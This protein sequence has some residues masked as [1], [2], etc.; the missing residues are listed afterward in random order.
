LVVDHDDDVTFEGQVA[1]NG[2]LGF[3]NKYCTLKGRYFRVCSKKGGAGKGMSVVSFEEAMDELEIKRT[4]GEYRIT[5]AT[6]GKDVVCRLVNMLEYKLWVTALK[7]ALN[8]KGSEMGELRK[9]RKKVDRTIREAKKLHQRATDRE[10]ERQALIEEKVSQEKFNLLKEEEKE[11]ALEDWEE[12]AKLRKKESQERQRGATRKSNRTS[13]AKER[14]KGARSGS[15]PR[16][17]KSGNELDTAIESTVNSTID[18]SVLDA[19]EALDTSVLSEG[20]D[21]TSRTTDSQ[22]QQE[23]HRLEQAQAEA[24]IVTK[25]SMELFYEDNCANQ[26]AYQEALDGIDNLLAVASTAE[27][28]ELCQELFGKQPVV[29]TGEKIRTSLR[30]VAQLVVTTRRQ[31][32]QEVEPES[33]NRKKRQQGKDKRDKK[34]KKDK[35]NRRDK[36]RKGEET[37]GAVLLPDMLADSGTAGASSQAAAAPAAPAA[38]AATATTAAAPP[39]PA[40]AASRAWAPGASVAA[41]PAPA[42]AASHSWASPDIR[43]MTLAEGGEWNANFAKADPSADEEVVLNSNAA[44][45][46]STVETTGAPRGASADS[47]EPTTS[48]TP[49]KSTE[50]SELI[51]PSAGVPSP[52][53]QSITDIEAAKGLRSSAQASGHSRGGG[54]RGGSRGGSLGFALPGMGQLAGVAGG[55]GTS[56]LKSSGRKM[57]V[58]RSGGDNRDFSASIGAASRPSALKSSGRKMTLASGIDGDEDGVEKKNFSSSMGAPGGRGGRGGGGGGKSEKSFSGSLG[59]GVLGGHRV[60]LDQDGGKKK[61]NEA[62]KKNKPPSVDSMEKLSATGGLFANSEHQE[63]KTIVV[64]SINFS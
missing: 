1:I 46:T 18:V 6:D 22:D 14:K 4:G 39:A 30:D 10:A 45:H 61:K 29:T 51:A 38:T 24:E 41:P 27:V 64:S 34:A 54:S 2:A 60:T 36:G 53:T 59:A 11:K 62:K 37:D 7:A 48:S 5:I 50:P 9:Q 57:T 12:K 15:K 19:N 26:Q 13:L 31:V 28:L 47:C 16:L 25:E 43:K 3:S 44:S 55:V 33:P 42:S 8:P 35:S 63:R 49:T 21:T 52:N 23:Q 56:L 32:E 17:D 58:D 20:V 40:S